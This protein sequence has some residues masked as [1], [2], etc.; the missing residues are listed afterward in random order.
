M[1]INLSNIK[2]GVG[3]T[4]IAINM[5]SYIASEG[6]KVLL[7]D[8][9][10]QGKVLQWQSMSNNETFNVIHHPYDKLHLD[11]H[12]LSEGYEH[13]I[14]DAPPSICKITLSALLASNLVIV[15]IEPSP[16]SSWLSLEIVSLIKDARKHNRGLV[17]RFLMSRMVTGTAVG[18][19]AKNNLDSY[20]MDL[21]NTEICQRTDFVKAMLQG[22][23]IFEYSPKSEAAKNI[24]SLCRE[25]IK[26]FGKI[27]FE[28]PST[29]KLLVKTKLEYSPKS[30]AAKKIQSLKTKLLAK[31][32]NIIDEF[33]II[34]R[35][36]RYHPRKIPLIVVDFVIQNRAHSGFIQNISRGGMFIETV[37]FFSVGQELT[38]A[39][40]YPEKQKHIKISGI[41]V[42]IEPNGIGVKF[43]DSL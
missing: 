17:G 22:L 40:F 21:I 15:P 35:E 9:D 1:I 41:V 11:I 33:K 16:L 42:R 7:V 39:F 36:K 20:G 12:D 23:S 29:E 2:G 26:K 18:R 19:D 25:V 34:V 5:A 6:S 14:I 38:M 31:T 10:P 43:K 28:I 32:K 24:Q 27:N 30:A 4:T 3:K 37:E 13:T 8:A